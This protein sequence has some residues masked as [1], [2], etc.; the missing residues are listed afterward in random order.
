MIPR[1]I[2]V[3]VKNSSRLNH[4]TG[5][6][7]ILLM[8]LIIA[9]ILSTIMIYLS[10][11]DLYQAM[12]AINEAGYLSIPN[13]K[14]LDSLREFSPAVFGGL[15]FTFSTGAALSIYALGAVWTWDRLAKGDALKILS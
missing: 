13:Q 1:R 15:F 3:T 14:T 7:G 12:R 2:L 5:A 9:Q 11:A 6:S 8:G 4:T 10:N